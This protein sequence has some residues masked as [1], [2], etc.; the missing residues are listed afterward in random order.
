MYD[1][2]SIEYFCLSSNVFIITSYPLKLI[3]AFSSP[4]SVAHKI[5]HR[6]LP[7][8]WLIDFLEMSGLMNLG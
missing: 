2:G 5:Q 7:V 4:A 8:V 1:T 6:G 3:R